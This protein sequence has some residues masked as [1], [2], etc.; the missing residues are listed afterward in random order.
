MHMYIYIYNVGPVANGLG[1]LLAN[2]C[3]QIQK[4]TNIKI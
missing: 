4:Y 3:I 1:S 2:Q